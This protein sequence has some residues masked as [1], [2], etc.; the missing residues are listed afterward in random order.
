MNNFSES[1][2]NGDHEK[3][4]DFLLKEYDNIANAHFKSN[5]NITNFF[6][7]YLVII[8]FPLTLFT[9]LFNLNLIKDFINYNTENIKLP[10]LVLGIFFVIIS[11]VGFAI[12]LYSL[13]IHFDGI[14]YAR[15]INGIRKYF[16]DHEQSHGIQ[17][18]HKYRV[19][20]QST[21]LPSYRDFQ[22][23]GPIIFAF[24]VIN[25]SY[26]FIATHLIGYYLAK[27]KYLDGVIKYESN[28]FWYLLV[29]S[30]L[31]LFIHLCT[32]LSAGN[33]REFSYLR[34]NY[35][36]VDID[37]V[38]NKH[39]E[40]FCDFLQKN[41]G[42]EL[43]PE[44]ITH[45]P[46][47]DIPN[48]NITQDDEIAVFNDP[49]Y[50]IK[51]PPQD[52]AA[53]ILK[54]LSNSLSLKIYI[55]TLRPWPDVTVEETKIKEWKKASEFY[56]HEVLGP[57]IM[58]FIKYPFYKIVK[59]FPPKILIILL[60]TFFQF[61]GRI[62]WKYFPMEKITRSWL[63][64]NGIIYDHLFLERTSE[65]VSDPSAK[66]FNRFYISRNIPIRFFVEDDVNKA[67]KLSF[68]CD[69][70]FLIQHPYNKTSN[71]PNN[72]IPVKDWNELYKKIK[73]LW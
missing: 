43:L 23:F 60:I 3:F 27:I 4:L 53:K 2:E 70:V 47:R 48:K 73:E 61:I 62:S 34:S 42:K 38:L 37:G 63:K 35:I 17:V 33:R 24:C 46:V 40:Q 67:I 65:N 39:R 45:I 56:A 32:Y 10:I 26:F 11:L 57:K 72:V 68:I 64:D 22:F 41:T 59:V 1:T 49:N 31:W 71:V 21:A 51:M 66:V 14:F 15:T 6:K 9:A 55:F 50:W 8:S 58:R 69:F 54:K 36:G 30:I 20:P 16:F 28:V 18:K 19:L 7:S 12:Y 13:N 29:G 52:D 25:F 44:E 5:E